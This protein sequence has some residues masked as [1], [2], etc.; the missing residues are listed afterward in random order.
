MPS[1]E[2][3]GFRVGNT[4]DALL[5]PTDSDSTSLLGTGERRPGADFLAGVE[6]VRLGEGGADVDPAREFEAAAPCAGF[7]ATGRASWRSWKVDVHLWTR[8]WPLL[9]S[10]TFCIGSTACLQACG[11]DSSLWLWDHCWQGVSQ[12]G[13]T[14]KALW[15]SQM[16]RNVMQEASGVGK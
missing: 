8:A 4:F 2:V 3:V 5:L 14:L 7:C 11:F 10:S 1:I 9:A 13:A 16:A 6:A 12:L 15:C